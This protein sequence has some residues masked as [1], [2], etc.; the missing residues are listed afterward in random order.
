MQTPGNNRADHDRRPRGE[1][2]RNRP[3]HLY[4]SNAVIGLH[5]YKT[6]ARYA[7]SAN[8]CHHDSVCQHNRRDQS[9]ARGPV[10]GQGESRNRGVPPSRV[11]IMGAQGGSLYN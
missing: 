3:N 5:S 1:E 9:G 2:E 10:K 11:A 8:A 6:M 4:E 7:Q